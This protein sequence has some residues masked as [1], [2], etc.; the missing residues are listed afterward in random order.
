MSFEAP[1]DA[2]F[3]FGFACCPRTYS[4]S[5]GEGPASGIPWYVSWEKPWHPLPEVC[6]FGYKLS[7]MWGKWTL[8]SFE[9]VQIMFVPLFK[10]RW[11]SFQEWGADM[12]WW[13]EAGSSSSDSVIQQ[14][15]QFV[16]SPNLVVPISNS[17][18]L[19][20]PTCKKGVSTSS[21]PQKNFGK[22]C[23]N[24]RYE[25]WLLLVANINTENE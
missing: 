16:E 11:R 15:A 1:T 12:F 3:S 13:I 10:S 18:W 19:Q 22:L 20:D 24:C 17:S 5:K 25:L 4:F 23:H 8:T 9:Y 14:A 7:K 21:T 2:S 6:N